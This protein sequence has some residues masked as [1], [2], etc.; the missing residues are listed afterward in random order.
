M[1]SAV[2]LER[3]SRFSSLP[4]WMIISWPLRRMTNESFRSFAKQKYYESMKQGMNR[5]EHKEIKWVRE[6]PTAEQ[7]MPSRSQTLP[8]RSEATRN[9][10]FWQT[11]RRVKIDI[12]L[13]LSVLS[14]KCPFHNP[15]TQNI[16]GCPNK[17]NHW[18]QSFWT[19]LCWKRIFTNGKCSFDHAR[20]NVKEKR[21]AQKCT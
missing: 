2:P 19:I 4:S 12:G 7:R 20:T 1:P 10:L 8:Q 3:I 16:C 17:R 6:C 21:C 14:W 11:K 13:R 5:I 15:F 18:K 9:A